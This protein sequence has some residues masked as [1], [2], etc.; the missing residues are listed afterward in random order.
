MLK[1]ATHA[2]LKGQP[3]GMQR[4]PF[5]LTLHPF[6]LSTRREARQARAS[7]SEIRREF[8]RGACSTLLSL[9]RTQTNRLSSVH[10]I[11]NSPLTFFL[12]HFLLQKR[13]MDAYSSIK[14]RTDTANPVL[15]PMWVIKI[16]E[17]LLLRPGDLSHH[18][19]LKRSGA[20]ELWLPGMEVS[21]PSSD[22]ASTGAHLSTQMI[23]RL[24]L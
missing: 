13:F 8:A 10:H 23:Y 14:V 11:A 6:Y 18:Q 9:A 12:A 1:C 22:T 7:Y 15:F 19:A 20:I 2:E 5:L 16:S 17:F 3:F 4:A 21:L 24:L